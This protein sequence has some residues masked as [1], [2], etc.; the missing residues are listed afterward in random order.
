[1]KRSCKHIDI[2]DWKTVLPWV[3]E[4]IFRHRDR[5]DFQ[6]LLRD[7]GCIVEEDWDGTIHAIA[8]YAATSIKNR[9]LILRPV[10]IREKRDVS[11]LK[12]RLIGEESAMQQV[13][14][15]IAVRACEEI[16]QRRIVP[17]QSSSI[18]GRGQVY[19]TAMISRWIRK[20]R[21]AANYAKNHRLK[22]SRKCRYF[23][24]LDVKKCYQS[25]R[26]GCFMK[27]FARDCANED[28][29]WLWRSLLFRHRVLITDTEKIY[30][31][32]MI[33][34][35]P[36]QQAAQY[37]LSFLYRFAMGLHKTRRSI[38][39]KVVTHMELFMDDMLLFSSDKRNLKSAVRK[40]IMFANRQFNITIKPNWQICDIDKTPV[41]MMGYVVHADGNVTIRP[42]VFLRTRRLAL[43]IMRRGSI[44]YR[45]AMRLSSYKGFFFQRQKR[46]CFP[47]KSQKISK[48]LHLQSL[49][50]SASRLIGNRERRKHACCIQLQ[51]G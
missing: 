18:P 9:E 20:D 44:S 14:D 24:K 16:W 26:V 6:H 34:A 15:Y 32:F 38:Q 7:F 51:A 36:S 17:Q 3:Q 49:F 37:I 46:I 45:Q 8:K 35:L 25:M 5:Y 50:K 33:G 1:M 47:L 31:G 48:K 30:E 41:D 40:V 29:L 4:C 2:T 10:H 22:Y 27:L 39:T 28:L 42:R 23:V 19:G 11:S 43:R 12:L 21:R 13:F